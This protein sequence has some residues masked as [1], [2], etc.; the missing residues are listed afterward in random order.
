MDMTSG[1]ET[2]VVSVPS[3]VV[4]TG[5]WQPSDEEQPVLTISMIYDKNVLGFLRELSFTVNQIQELEVKMSGPSGTVTEVKKIYD[6]KDNTIVIKLDESTLVQAVT[7]KLT[8][9]GS[10]ALVNELTVQSC[11]KLKHTTVTPTRTT[12]T[13]T[14]ARPATTTGVTGTTAPGTTSAPRTTAAPPTTRPPIRTTTV[15]GVCPSG[16][17]EL[18]ITNN[19]VKDVTDQVTSSTPSDDTVPTNAFDGSPK[20]LTLVP[21]QDGQVFMELT[22]PEPVPLMSVVVTVGNADSVTILVKR[23]ERDTIFAPIAEE[24]L[25]QPSIPETVEKQFPGDEVFV[26]RI[27]FKPANNEDVVVKDLTVTTCSEVI[28]TTVRPPRTTTPIT[29]APPVTT[30]GVTGTTAPGTTSAPRTT[31]APPTTRPPIRTTTVPV[32]CPSGTSELPITNNNVKDVIDQVTSSTPSD[33]TVPTNAFD[34]SPKD[35]TLI[36]LEDGQVFV[37]LTFPEPVP[38]MSVV[39]TVENAESVTIQVK[40][41]ERDTTFEPIA[42]E[43][44]GQPTLP[45]TVEK[46]F[47]GDEVFVV[48]IVFKPANNEDVVVKD[49]TVTTCSEEISTTVRPPRTTAPI[50]TAPPVT[51]TGVTGTTAPSTTS[52]PRTTAASPTTRP[53]IRTTTVPGVCPSGTSELPITNNN[54]KD[55]IDQVTSSTPSDDTVPT[56]AF[57]G[58]PKDLTLIPLEDG[59]VFVELTF[60]EP[61]PLMSV[62][63]TVENAESVTIQ[64]KRDER[65]TTFEPIAEETIGQPTLPE[66]VEKLFPGDE[67]FVVRI[68]FKPANNED[69]VVK[70]L[71]VTT[72]S[73]EISTTVRPPR[74]T[75]PITTAPPVRTTGVTGTTAPGT[76]SAPRTTAAP[77]TTRPPIRTTTVPGVCPSG[78]SELP[79]TNNNVK[80]VIDQVTSSTPSDDT[81]PTNAFDGSPKDLTL[82]PLEDGQVFVELTF[83]EPVPLMSVV[84]TVENAESV[85][86]QVKRDERDTT[87]EPIAEETIGQPTLPE[88]VEKLFPGDEVFVVRIV[89]KP[90]NNEDVVVKDLTVTTCSEEIST[91]VR[92]PRTTAPITT[93]PPVTTTGVTGTTAPGT[94]SAPRTT[95][96]P[97]T[98]RPPIRTTTVPGVCPSGTSELPITNNNVKDVIDQVTSSTPSDDTVPTNAFDGSPKDLTLIPLEDGQVFVE[99]TFPE[100]VPLMSV[101]VTVENAES[102][103]IQVK[104]DERDTTFEPIAEET[105]GQPTLPETVEK[106]FPGDEVFVVRIVFK[107]A[108]NEDVVVKDLTVTTCSEEISTTVRPPRT[109]APITTAPP[110]RTTGVTGTTA[111]GTTSAPRTT[112][113]P[114]TTR[115]PIRTTTVP[116]VCPSGT[117]ELPIT[118]NN[119]RDVIDQV[120]SS[121][122]SDDTVPTNAFDGSPKDL[123]LIPLEDGQVF[124][125]LTFPE[126]VPLM[127]VVV[128]VENAESVTIQVKRD[129]RDTTFEPIAEE[130]IGQPTLPETV[131]K[132]FPGDEVFVVRIVF[133][134]AN[135]ED[136][137]VKDLTVTTCSEEIS[138]TVRPPRTTAPITTAPPVTTTGVTGTTAPGTTSAPRTTAA[139]PTTRPPIR[140]TTVPGVC[141]SGTSEL[142]IT[143]NNVKDVIDQVTS[144]TP[145]D[146]TVPTNAF[147]GSPK[148]LTLIPLEDGQVFVELTFPEPVP[149]M[150][151]VVTVENAE[152]VTIQVKRD[153]RDTTFEPIAEE[154][155]GQPT[156]PETVEKLFPGDEVF[157]VRIV[158]KPANNE[159][160]VVKDLTVTTCSEE[161]S[162]TVRP[163]RTTAPITTAPPVTTTGVTGTTAPGT[164][165][166][167]RTTAAPPTTRPPIRT[168][169][170]PGVC[171]SGTSELPITNNN[172]K[173]VIDQVTSSTP[174]DDT[175]PTNA[176]DGSPKDLTLIP[177]EDGQVFVELT[178]PEPVPLMSVV[179]TVENAESVTIQVK[180][181]ERDTTFE[182]IAEETIGQPTLPETVEKLFPGDEVFVVRI[183]FKPANN[184][185]VIVKDLTV[186]TC[187]EEISTTVRPPR[188]TAPITTAPP[189]T[190]TGVTG[191]TA[192]G[193]TSAPRTTAAPPTTRPP[194]R[195]T[196]VPGVC[197]S[198]TSELPI[199]NN[200]VKD[201]I[202]QVTS[203][204]PSDD[205]VPTNAFDGSPKDLTLIPLEDGQVFVELTFPEPVPLMSVVV[206]VE[207][208]ESVTIQVKR[209]ERDTTFEP[210]AEETIGQPTLPETVEKLF[211]GDEVF[212][213]R[214]V[215]KPANNED[216]VVKD[217]TVTTCSEEISTTVRPPRTTA[218]ITTAPPV[219]TTG[220]TGTT[221]PGTTSAP[222]TTAAPPTTRPPIRTTTVPGVCP[223][224]T[225]E[226]PITNNNVRDV[227]DQV[228]SSTPSDDTVP[229]NAFDGSPKDLTLIPL[230]DGQVFVELTFPEP[231]P[232]M[233]VVVTVENAESVTIQVKRD[234]RDTTFEPIAEETIGQP[235]LPET[236]EKL[237]PGDE[238]FVVRIVFKP[239]NN[240]DVVVKDLTVTT[241]SEEISTTVR[242]PRT[243]APIT[244]A[245]PVRTTGV[246]GTT[247]P[248]TTSAPRTTAAPPT[249]RPPIRTTTVPGVCPSG[250]SELPITNNNVRDV[251]DQVTSST[252]SDDTVPTNA[253]DG[254]PK[255][256]TLIPLEDGQVFVELTFPEPVPLMSVVVTVENAE[257]VT[258]QVKR[259]ERDTTFEPIAEET[260]G[261]PT[262][263]ETVEK[264]FPGDEV[265]VVRIVFKPANNEDVVVKDLTVTTCSEE[266]STTVRPPRTTAPITTA[267]PVR[268]TGV[269]GT[270]AP[271]TTSAPRTTAAPPTT[272]PPIRTTTVPGVCPSGTSELPI[273]NNNVKDVIDQVTSSTP[274]DD[275][276]PT[277]AFDGSPKDLTLIPLEDGQVFVE[278]TFPEPVPLMSVVVTV[279]NAESVTIQVKRDE[280]DTTF[281]PIAEETIGQPT[282]PETV[283]K[284][285]PGDEV[286]VVRIVFKPANNED[287]VVKDLTVTTCSE[288]ISTTVRPPRTTAPIT[289][290]PPVRTTGVTGT[291]APGTTSAPRTTA[292]PPTTRPPIR[293]TTV[294]GVCPSGTSELPITNNNV[295]DVIDQVTS[296]TPSDDTVPT[297]A[298]DGSPKD[299]TLIPLEDGQVFV[300][301]TF[302]EPVP[303]M[304]VVVT[305]EN[306]ESV[307]IQ[308]K[309]DERDTTFEP[310]AEETIG[311]PTLPETVEKL[312]PG[313]EVFVVRIVFKPANNE[314]VVVKDL[315]VTTCSEEISTTV[316]PPRTTAPITTAPPVTTTGV[317]GTTAPG[318]TSAP[319]TTAA[320][321]TTRPPIRTTTVPGVCPSGT[322]ELPITNNN[323][324]DVIDQVTSSTPSDDTVPTNAFDGSPKDLTLIPLEDGQVFVELTFPEPVPLMSVVV[325][326][327]NAESVTIQVKRDERDT[328]FEPIAE[329]TIG[330]PTLPET[331]EKLF[332][333]DEVFVVRIVFKPANNEDVVVKDL[334]VTTCSEEISTTVRPPRTTAPIT[335]AP[336][337]TTTG[338]TGTTAPGTTSAPRT[339]AAPPTTRPPIRT[340]TVPG[341]CP[342]GTSELPITNNNVRDVIDQVT[343][344]TPSDDTVPTNAFDGSPKD[345]T[346]I[347]LEDGQ[348]FVELTF[349][350]P[351]PL[352]SVVVTV[353]NAESV[354]IQVKR[355]ERDTTFEPIAEETIGQP[356]LPE[357]VEKLF[358]GDEVFVVRIV[359][360]PANNE[361]VVV[362]D[363]TVTTC[364]EEISTTVRPPRTTAPITTAPPVTTTGVTGTTAPGTTSAP[365]TTAAPP[366]TRPPIRTTT[367]PGVCPS[368]TSELPI[369]NN[370][371]KDVIDQVT[372]STPS[373]DTV[374]TNAFDGSPKDLTLIPLEDGQVFV[375]LTFPE[376]VPLMSVVVTVE[377]AESVTIQVKRDERDTTFEPI[378]E[379]TIGQP[380]L[381][382]T[383]E[384]LFPGDEVFVVR[385][386]FKPANN[387][388][389]VVKDLTVTTCS[390]EIST[391]VRPP[392]TTAPITTAP[393]VTTTGVT[394]TTAPGTTSAPRTTAAPPTT[395]PPIRTTTVPGVCPSGTSELP[396]TNNNVRDVI[397]QVTS[398]TPSDDTVP[399]NAFDGS[400][401]DL[402]LI[403]LEDG[404]VFVEL[405]FPEPVPLMSVVVTVENA[406]SV[407]IQVKRDERDTTFEPI[408]EETI[409]QPTLPETVE[410]LFPGD[411]VFVVRIVFKPANNEDV[412]VKDLTVTTCS[413]EIST[414]VRPPRTTAPITTAPPVRTT[415]VTG[416]T[417]P[418]TTSAPRTTAAPPT[419]RPPI[420]TTTVPG[421]CPSGTS[422]LPITNNNVKDVIDQVTSST[423][424]DDTVP[425][426]AFDG[427][428]KDLTL[429]PLE[430]G[431]VFVELTFPEP[432]P[433]M[434]VVV[435]VEN[436]ESVTI[437][438]KRDE[439][440]TT[441]EP[442]A[443]ETIGQPTLPETVEKLFPGDEVF[444]VRIVFKPANNEDVVVKDLTVTTCSE[445]ISTTVRPPR[446]TAPITTAPPVTTTGVTGTTAPG[447]TSAPRTT[448]A[449]P[450]TRPP[451]RTTTVPGVCPSGTS[452]L[453][454]TNNNVKDVIDQVTSS[455]PS[456][457]T[458]PTNAFDGSPK[459]LTL[460]PLEDGQVFVEL[461]FPEPVPLMSV[462]VTVEN[463]ESVTIQVKRDERDTTFE[464]IAEETIGQPTL[465]ETVEKLFPGDEVFV[466]R[467]VFKPANNEDVVVKDLTV[468]TCSEEISTTVR[469]PRTTAPITT[470]PPVTTTGVTGTTA[471]GTTSAPRTTAAPPTTR[472]PIRTTTVPGVCPSGTSELPITNNNVKDVIDQVT[473][474]TPSDY[475]VPTNAFD[476]SPKDLTL[477]PLEDGQVFV[478]LTFPEPVPL[479]SVVVTV[480]NAESVTIQVK[481]DERD[482]TFE[483]IAEETIGQPTLPE[484]VEKLFPGDEVFV[485]RIVFKP[486]NNE[487]V[488][489][490]D[491][492]VT[493]C[494]E[495]I[496]TTV[497]PPRTTAPITTAPPVRTTGVTGTTAPGTTSAPR[498]TAAPPTTR[499][500][501]R[502]TTVP[503]VCPS[504][505]S[506][507]PI[508]NN[509]VRDVIDQVTSSTPSDDTVPTNAFDGSP[510]DL[511]LIPLEDGQVFVEL[512]FPEPVPLMSVVVTVENAESVTIQVK[513]DE[514]DT[515]FEPIAEETIGQ[516]TLP[517]TVEKLFPGDEVFVVRIVFKPA[518]N[519]DV[520]V[521]DLTVTTCSEEISTTV[522]PP[523]TTAPITTAPPVTTTG[524]TG[525]TAPGTTSAPR[526]TAAPPTTRPPIR[527][528]TVPGVCPSGT[529]ELPITNNNV[530]DVIDQVTSSTPSDDTVPTNAFDG[531]PKDLTLT[532]LEDGQ[533]FVELTFP[534]PVPLMSVVV[535]VEN[536]ES[537][538][539][540]VKRDE[541]DTTFEP[542][543]EETI[544][545]PTLPETVEKLFPG[546]EVFVVRIVF[547]PANNEDVVVKDL[548]VTTCSE[549]ISTTVRPPRTT[550]P[551]TTAPPV[552]TTGV[553]GTTAP[554]TT[555]APRTTAAPP[556]TR[557]P[558]RTTTVP[559][560]CPSGTSELPITNNNVKDV[561]DQVT[562]STPSDYTVPTNA[563]DGSPKD[564]TL[565]PLEDG[566][567]FVEL[568]F[569]EPVPLM[570]VVVTVENAE[571]V[572]IQVKRDERDTTFE[573]IAEE[574]IG[575]PT[576]PETV[577]K[578][579][580]GDE[581][582]VVRIVFKPANNEDVVVKDL[583]VTTC[584]EEI[585]TTV[586]PPRTTAPITTAPPVR[587]TGVTGTTAPGTTSAPRTTAAPPTTRPPIRTTT[588]PGVCPSGTSELPI[589]NNNVRDVI[590]QVTSSTPS[591]DTVPTNAFDG[592]PKDLTLIPLED[593]QVFVELTFPEPVPLMS[594]VVTVENAESVTIQVK[595]DERDT[596]FEPIAEE[597]I[598]QPTLPETVE[599]LFPGDEVFVVRIVFK[600]ANNEDVVVKDLTVTTCS[601]EISTTVRPPRTTAPITT[602][603]PVTTTGVTGTTAPGTTSA[604]RTTAA[605]PT[606]RP[607]IRTTTVPGVCPSGTSE[608]PIT[609]NNVK[610]VIDQVT[611]ST[612]SDYTVPTNAF[613]GSPK[614]LTLIPLEDGQ[615]FVEL[616]FPEP[617]P[618]MSVVVTVENAESVTIQ[619]KRDER[620]TTFEPIA[621]ETIGQPTL[622]ETV[623]KLFPGDEVFVVRIVFKPANN[624][625]VVVKDLTVTTCSEEISTTV[626]PPR[627]TAPITTAPPV[628]TTGVT[629]TT[630]PGTTS[631]PRTTAAPPTTRPPIRTTTVPGVCPSGT[632]ELPIT[633]TNVRD[634]IDQVTSS[635]PS[636]DTVPTNAFDG[637]PKDL[638]LIPLEDGQVFV[639]LTF[640]EP[641]PLM[642]VVVT[643]ENA[644]SV[645]IQVKRDERDTT[646]EPIAEE[647]IGQPT[648]PETVEK[649][650]P[651]DEVF[652][653]RIVFKPANNEDVVVKDLTVTTCSEEISTT[654]RPPRTTAPITTAPPVT[655]TGV[656]GTTAPGTTSAPRTTAAPPTT[657]PPIRTTTVPGVCPSGTSE[658]PITNNNVKDVI[659]QVTSSTPSD[660]TVPTNAFD[661]SPKDL[662]LI[663]LEDGQVFVELTFPEPVP[664]MSVVVTVE[665]AESVT[666]Q[667]KRDERDTTFEPIAE[668][669]IG[670]PTLPETVEKLFPG[671]EV[672]VVRIVFKPANNEDVVVK[673]LT[674][675]TCSE[676]ISTT[677]RPP[678]TTAPITTAPPVRTTGVTGTTAPGTTSAPRTTAAPPTTRPP[679]RTTT[680][681]GVCPSGT[682]E[683]P[684]TNTNVRDV[685]DQVTSSTPSDDTV[686]T[687]AFDGSPKDLTLIPLEDGQVFVELTF[688]EPVPLMSVVVTVENA[689]SVT[690][691]V[692]R[693]ERDTTFEPIAEETIGQPTL[694]ETVEKLFPGDEV[695][696]VRIVFKPANNEDIVVKDLT[697]TTCS[698]EISTTVRPPRTTAPI[699]TA[700]PVTTTGVTGTTAPGTTSAP[701]T[702]AAPPT[703][704]PPIRTTT[705]P[706]VCPSG[707]SELPITN[708]NVKDVIDQVTSSTPSDDTVP[709]NAFDGSPKD[710]TLT[711]LED[712]Q[713][714]VELTFPE[715]VPLMSVVVTVENAESVTIQ[716]KRDERDTTFEPI[717]EE[718]I[719]QPT[720]P[721]TVEKLFPGDEVFVVRIVFK[722]ANNEDVVVKDLTVT[723]CSEEISTT[724]RPPRTTA[725]ITTAPPVTTTG[726]TGTTAPGTTSAPRTT[727]APPTTRPPIRTTTVPGVCPSGTSELPITNNNVKDV[728]D[729]VTS[730]TPSDDTV[731][732]N[733]FD[734][735]PKDLT[736]TPLEDGQVFVELTFP[737]PV[738]LMSVVVT[739]ENAESV[740][741]QVKRDER[742]TT[743]E[744]I[745]EE[746][747]GQPTLPETVEKL[748]PGDEVFVVR[749]VF[750]PANNED[751]VVKDLTVTTCSEEISTTV[752]PPRT[753]A[754]ITTAPPVR[755]TGVTGTTAPGTTSAPR[756]TA[757]P[758]TTRPPI[759]TTTVPGVC[760]SG[761]SELP[762]TNN[763]VKDVID[764]VT[765]STPSDD[766]VPTNAFDGSPKD[767]TLTPLEDGQVFV[768]LTFP[769]PVPLMSVVVTVENAESV[770]IQVK[771]DERDTTFEPIA[772]ETIG[773]P[774]L[775]ETVEKL[776]PGDEVFVVRIVFKPAN[777]EDVVVKDLTVTT[778][779]EEISTTVRPPRTTAPITTAPPVT[780]TGVTGTTAPGTTSAPR[781]TAAP[782][783]TR[784]PIRTTTVPGV[785]PSGTSELP[786]TNNNVKDVIDQVTSSTPSDDTVPTNAFD[787]SPK[788]LTLIPLEDGQV[789]VELTFPEPVPLMSVVVTV[790]NAESVTIQVKR[791]ERD[792]TF[793]PIA[794]ETI[795]QPTLPETVEKLFPGDEVFVVRI[796]FKPANNEDVVVKDLTVTTCSEEISTTVRPPRT[797][798]PITTAP[799]VRTTGV[800]G[801]TAPGTTSAPR[802][803]AA[804]PTTRPPI[805][806]TTVPGVCPSGTSELPITNT[807]VRDV[808]DQVTSSTPSDDTVP[809]NAFDGSPKDLT[810]IPLEDGQVFVELTFPEPVPLMSVLVTVENAESV[811]IQVK[812][813]ER[814]TTFEPIAE[815]TIGQPTLPETV[816]KLFPGDEVFVVRIV[817]KPANNEDVVVK[818]LTVTTCSEEISTTVRPPRTTAPIT[819]A[820]PVTTTG[821]TGTTAPGTTSAPRTT[822]A[823]PTTRPPIRTTTVP[824]VCPSGTSELPITNNNVKD[825]IDQ[826][827]SSTPSDYTVPTNAF[828]GSPKDLTLIPLEDGQVFVE[829]T[830]PEPVPLMSVVVTVENAESVTIQVKRDERD[831]TFEPIAEE[832]IGQPTLPETVEKLFPGDEV[833]VVRIVFK[834]AN[835]EDV[836][837][838]DLTVTTCSEE[839][840]TTVRP[841]RTT[842]PI[843]TAPPVTTTGVTGTTAPGTTSAPRTTAAPPTT[844][845]PIRTTTVPG[846]CPSGTSELPITNNN[847]KDVID[848]VTSSTPSD[849]TVPTNAFD[850]SPK[851]LTL[852]P[853]EDGQVFVELTFPEPVPL[854][855]VVVTVENAESVTIQVKRDER[856]T[857]FEPIAEETIGQPTL[858]ET[859]EKLFP[860]DEVFVVRIVFKPANNE[861][862]VVKDLT[863]TTC[864]EEI[865][866]SDGSKF[867]L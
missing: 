48:R 12:S 28:S 185:D 431:Q 235:T 281:E 662:T 612:P 46:L 66:T 351:V 324:K 540:Q 256:L 80:D 41:D 200:N 420:R 22:F 481:R 18:P 68:V 841:P 722:P 822:A 660:Y 671:D 485:V 440:D 259:D 777:N 724:V 850:G 494:S 33:D 746:T 670:Q 523:R 23:D 656:T 159:D 666:I 692:K 603:P 10:D 400:P 344:S 505:T 463:A 14:T 484:T 676:E 467:I 639:E 731:P 327:E 397:D 810:L 655:T 43:T 76:T 489:V 137:V 799:P 839:I 723:T 755:T 405:T 419:T 814:D 330:Q 196:T 637:S 595:R 113:A 599:K 247:A 512:T 368:G 833:F 78:T 782:P 815:E 522:R 518:N 811:T 315:T 832:T 280:R 525:T 124:V 487:D 812:R 145:S 816:E 762:I 825:V 104:R 437:Q 686:P 380:T 713:V 597:T 140:T 119:V 339:T 499:P 465:P 16:T 226:L 728:I 36:P 118:N 588:V 860:G 521:K 285:F 275:T 500:P 15:P 453:P 115:P 254:S 462:V 827:T 343:S 695:F 685:I 362:K 257:S 554:G 659:D 555:S 863:V 493:T 133:K 365:R 204:T 529:S 341:V 638:T 77:P 721:E 20:G 745:A 223:S 19:N 675:T 516:P 630:A 441:F 151:V 535:T 865:S 776:F 502:T 464:P 558:I 743:F 31:A 269:T 116:G 773:Q 794:E 30:T 371:V 740:T 605:P 690:I 342:S 534:E 820:P 678:R 138:T 253:F 93:A 208:A 350:E 383:V 363:L 807:N 7:L 593:G 565:I 39:V 274:S 569:P 447:T 806:T 619:V 423:P 310:I 325:T 491:L 262:L 449:P 476:G 272:R 450:T 172:V 786:I 220:V 395:R 546:D 725:P 632:S 184:E 367:V 726:V 288:E 1:D 849:Y 803:T 413:E 802:T 144:S 753:T 510:K 556:T 432:V 480:E 312:F 650:F 503:G 418:G 856:D 50:T 497:R 267:P 157:V 583:T 190:T 712:G 359:F 669:T 214:I 8:D 59:Q 126:P 633:N 514:R 768:E 336:P 443:E 613:D 276:V 4:Q 821:V 586:R 320:P 778:C 318:T 265:F 828:D 859:V 623:E 615:V 244:T 718:T 29:T 165:S 246:T 295:K 396:I 717:A 691:Q 785:C 661:G 120:T 408:A 63:V 286:F 705:V 326:V 353:E 121:T 784:P 411:E 568:T 764:Q 702:T 741:I 830:F 742:D 51:T 646:F 864:S 427:S 314:D 127:S 526:T 44:I 369:T 211:P 477:I 748:F 424:S 179:V 292:A 789:F 388:D 426:N 733:A 122:P 592:S 192:P 754:P 108:N 103:T 384:K 629:G 668:E 750:K 862:V 559:G 378:A 3:S 338:V 601:E 800:T 134:P 49:L 250:T 547:K 72:C 857:T 24:T 709:T 317:T 544:G 433:L 840:S 160:V 361:D 53:P 129:E 364:S 744:P 626:R 835:N 663:P 548:T 58:S 708:N 268:T 79:I 649:L 404:Q 824:G 307:T 173:D 434:S 478:E 375:E 549:E 645:T 147:D 795:G 793:E 153:E 229:T 563:F 136:V 319:R 631:A 454:I 654:V 349:P 561:I 710:L 791:D 277:N 417:A 608:L 848:Q 146:D 579:F 60:P 166:A 474:S 851:D 572:T 352:M 604:P 248:G 299:L 448:A 693:D 684:I 451:I 270:T 757:A 511:T 132:L 11:I 297:N 759:R 706:G 846:V 430:D 711:P 382:E 545:Q 752:R 600:P 306:A 207:N 34:G 679:I 620:D 772:E 149:L 89:F 507:L 255:D 305:V 143:N 377:N 580:P 183:V 774:T 790:E 114:P 187:S 252:P 25:R 770:T 528:T 614:D 538:T 195:T 515:T 488:V 348:V 643:V 551:I 486:A 611:S 112:A 379:E 445:E 234:E 97:P 335:T 468:T 407:T 452:E 5:V 206:T 506:E 627:T 483:P 91:T 457:D 475:T 769:E 81:V 178:F 82:I 780:T 238:V 829:L 245:P 42:E 537:V 667:V 13:V 720:L 482:T 294:P 117:S 26:V 492:T 853:L 472:P 163:P 739:V 501:I 109:T 391:T 761:T 618:L 653:V 148:D 466:V 92:P 435:T 781:T 249:T 520:V 399:T 241:C 664:L 707:T 838:K 216:V 313:D 598:G 861:D 87:F 52:A 189:V 562:S 74:T 123:T 403:P 125:E 765:S 446:T 442:I 233:S 231:V 304:S 386:V 293:T 321:P 158:F 174:S 771:R 99:L 471:P 372:S 564:L 508:T 191:T 90:A 624:E 205:T 156:L 858:P 866:K 291:T 102:V 536:A 855:S 96:A 322:S 94:T 86:I 197:P 621:E 167:P 573:P 401:K 727:A 289:T 541:R 596:T 792:T 316:R 186:T 421:V 333:G 366:T 334:T 337:V 429:T 652:V 193:T 394:G 258:I 230:E 590:D 470:A 71:T 698:E 228:T 135:N 681:P 634:V 836:V 809:T 374:P 719:G 473:S 131:E 161:I 329:E 154:T 242:P 210:I 152:S 409:G 171:P 461:T 823:P 775:P 6:Q 110:V 665:N 688:P 574:T 264:L 826:V 531:S 130:T 239:A 390:E 164:T 198:G 524:V 302:P 203:S 107:P 570:S 553:T 303:L 243:T 54:V 749:I 519:E 38:L 56:N 469:P 783:T 696:V 376:P 438:V 642:S 530:K 677:V 867:L 209:D 370:N 539:I 175:V 700:P 747:I 2:N 594:V 459:D 805:R 496:S 701:R 763:N 55:V 298:F 658:L 218:P 21:L 385:I 283:E 402:T 513:R 357:T 290:A 64:V 647:T 85:T 543:A 88:T 328:T 98:T 201:V 331:V 308:V 842:A 142:P 222:R 587:T 801:T 69:V 194:I 412:V 67:V 181:D 170:V 735:S 532:P 837:V 61:V 779:S 644:E 577:E 101:V 582:F 550:A 581:V 300:E 651:G 657:R 732:T 490:K 415:G 797:T 332:P 498:T 47:P 155:I 736:L 852:I 219:R 311:Q 37:E 834:P 236:V 636:D 358:P 854:M 479:M 279:E 766:T 237:F 188:T 714:F 756:T 75:A 73:E 578:L 202:D 392:R 263:P 552:R 406:E 730:S 287:V 831:T 40:R 422:E 212:V 282:L 323:V 760:P 787:G 610:D 606:T 843:T 398:S 260:I 635:T 694:P 567:V 360:K 27:V 575:Q 169:T 509:N 225:S 199:T 804:P 105:I 414:T 751:V 346:L 251:I 100:P 296:S 798:A 584:S 439:R 674:V 648:L 17:S 168:T 141:P 628:T 444:V 57:D 436:A 560:V 517:E 95:A 340:T 221:A 284:L 9:F 416:T 847:V 389:V 703:T 213:V 456:D 716:V 617:V 355:D 455:T 622:P 215:F 687:N 609:N 347:P 788:D 715:P 527:T 542:I 261:Q 217:L 495:E 128:T 819:T 504:G 271:G 354:T 273:T 817:F 111:P 729:Q 182:P 301:L 232:L 737:E 680:V 150:S 533:V 309:R 758:P 224:G 139:P 356:T 767:L 576:L 796:V 373:D 227:I 625:D 278:L 738:P 65:D 35:L 697:V 672:F 683:L 589:T 689:E 387:E 640:P 808:I 177:L 106:L 83:P 460:T 641:V 240:E 844:R 673:D 607:P 70:D 682:S 602:A 699:T 393:P 180:R 176:F 266:I 62:V 734:G 813:D 571:S 410:K 704:R 458:V 345:L 557:P 45:E 381:P 566:Q 84:V 818:D 591:D 585:S 162:T 428:P 425:T 845:P 616:T 32:V